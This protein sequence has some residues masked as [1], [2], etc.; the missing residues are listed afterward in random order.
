M[1]KVGPSVNNGH[2]VYIQ[3]YMCMYN[4]PEHNYRLKLIEQH[5]LSDSSH[6]TP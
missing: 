5:L 6:T 3:M 4:V 2:Y 1:N